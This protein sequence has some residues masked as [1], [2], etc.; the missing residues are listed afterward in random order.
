VRVVGHLEG[1]RRA[2]GNCLGVSFLQTLKK[3]GG[4]I[5]LYRNFFD[6]YSSAAANKGEKQVK[7]PSQF[8]LLC[9]S[10]VAAALEYKIKKIAIQFDKTP[11]L[12]KGLQKLTPEA[13]S[14]RA[15]QAFEMAN[16]AHNTFKTKPKDGWRR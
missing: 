10:I 1:L 5:K 2:R 6:L 8:T 13:I 9:R 4:F 7:K 11:E 15:A 14:S 12:F 3:L 16:Y